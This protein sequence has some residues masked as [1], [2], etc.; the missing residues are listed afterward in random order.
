MVWSGD[1][2]APCKIDVNTLG[3]LMVA[4][5]LDRE[6]RK[7]HQVLDNAAWFMD[8]IAVRSAPASFSAGF[9]LFTYHAWFK[10]DD[11]VRKERWMLHLNAPER[12][13]AMAQF[14]LGSHW[15]AIQQ[16]RF[17]NV[18]RHLRCC[19]C[20][21]GQIEDE[22]HLLECPLYAEL[23]GRYGVCTRHGHTTDM[24]INE[25]FNRQNAR[26]WNRLAEFL[27][28]CKRLKSQDD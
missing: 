3:E 19:P 24:H 10:P 13:K 28:Q 27:V 14:R 12:I 16:G 26:D 21:P 8:P 5:W 4:Q 15:L 9:K 1:D 22:L 2:G 6:W 20:C 23:R 11:W 17:A 7:M 18:P 25:Q